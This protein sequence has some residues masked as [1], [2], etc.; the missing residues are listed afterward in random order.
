MNL[1]K[2]NKIEN[3]E[4]TEFRFTIKPL[5][6]QLPKKDLIAFLNT[7][8]LQMEF[9]R[10]S[11][12]PNQPMGFVSI[13]GTE[14]KERFI[15]KING[16][17]FGNKILSVS[18]TETVEEHRERKR[19]K[20]I[21]TN[22]QIK[23]IQNEPPKSISDVITPLLSLPYEKQLEHK[24]KH[25]KNQ[26]QKFRKK[27]YNEDR[28]NS[29]KWNVEFKTL[30]SGII[31]APQTQKY[32]NKVEFTISRD[33]TGSICVGFQIGQPK[34]DLFD[35]RWADECVNITDNSKKIAHDFAVF[36]NSSQI[37]VSNNWKEPNFWKKLTVRESWNT[38]E[39]MMN[40]FINP[41]FFDDPNHKQLESK[42]KEEKSRIVSFFC[43]NDYPL[44][45]TTIIMTESTSSFDMNIEE[46]GVEILF[47]KGFITEKVMDLNFQISPLSFFQTN[48]TTTEKIFG[49]V[50]DLV[51]KKVDQLDQVDQNSKNFFPRFQK[52]QTLLLDL[53]CGTGTIGLSL[54]KFVDLV[55][56]IEIVPSA[57]KDAEKNAEINDI[58]NSKF[59]CGKVEESLSKVLH[60][61]EVKKY[62]NI[63]CIV[64]PPRSGLPTK[65][66]KAIRKC[67]KIS[68]LIYVSCNI[69]TMSEN[70]FFLCK[71]PTKS[72]IND[73]FE[74]KIWYAIDA[75]PSTEH[76]EVV[77][78]L[79]RNEKN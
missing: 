48:T 13:K 47:G 61:E 58:K 34:L 38:K 42:I 45:I 66:I 53:C 78:L 15:N 23:R 3:D 4:E 65:T 41:K 19:K 28:S 77:M 7:L 18:A 68:R 16:S 37:Q 21:K 10:V 30:F 39:I 17:K 49:I 54:A 33:K 29:P 5:K 51:M 50:S 2:E 26:L 36:L 55:I 60:S 6:K 67:E 31:P 64:D 56:G 8:D 74:P 43:N 40:I 76:V 59:I 32:R 12:V 24:E 25:V 22:P 62:S 57:V 52:D 71:K 72:Y 63:V 11:K 73:P 27:I 44:S 14:N 9:F 35:V 75:F 70:L 79:T 69:K 46:S 1:I 20:A